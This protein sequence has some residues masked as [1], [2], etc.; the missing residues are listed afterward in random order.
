MAWK[1][2]QVQEKLSYRKIAL[3][4]DISSTM[5]SQIF[6]GDKQ[7]SLEMAFEIC[8]FL[9]L[10]NSEVDYFLL[11]VELQKAG[12]HKL[13]K[14]YHLRIK[15]FQNQQKTMESRIKSDLVLDQEQKE[16]F[17]SNWIYSATRMLT[18]L[19]EFQELNKI[20]HRLQTQEKTMIQI[21]EFLIKNNL[22]IKKNNKI[23]QGPAKTFIP[24]SSPL[25]QRHHSNWR[26]LGMQKMFPV[27]EQNLFYTCP[28]S[29]SKKVAD[30]IRKELPT[31]IEQ[32][33]KKVLD[34]DSEVVRCLNI[35]WFEF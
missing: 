1:N 28:M 24:A 34:S 22:C 17:Y 30:E 27:N 25:T 35:D 10:E 7:L 8:S 3:H 33:S 4:L 6:K 9:Q 31:F 26:L 11:L 19:P 2:Q 20:A 18:G 5:V 23:Q 29:I 13:K 15:E 14:H 32:I 16:I 12:S 21:I